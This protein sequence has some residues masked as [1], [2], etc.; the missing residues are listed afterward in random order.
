MREEERKAR[1]MTLQAAVHGERSDKP[2]AYPQAG[3]ANT[4]RSFD[5]YVRM[6]DLK[7]ETAASG[8]VLDVAGGASSF[9]AQLQERGIAATAADPFYAGEPERVLAEARKEIGVSSAKLAAAIASYDWSYYGSPERHR[10][11]REA[12]YVR[13]AADFTRSDAAS[14]YV[15]ASLP[16]LPFADESFSLTVCSH[17]LFLYGEQFDENFHRAALSE[18]LRVTRKGGEVCVYPLVTLAWQTPLYLPD[19]LKD[20]SGLA[21]V[22]TVPTALPFTPVR[23]PVLKLVKTGSI[24]SGTRE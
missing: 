2:P 22:R 4:C 23:S 21:I 13:F 5:E 9:T 20:L 11:L 24:S 7:M 18:M 12:S 16:R 1:G 3:V 6:F 19:L 14:R 17:F 8:P 10:E 15:A